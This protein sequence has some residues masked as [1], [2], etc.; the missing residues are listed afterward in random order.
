MLR[1]GQGSVPGSWLGFRAG[2]GTFVSD[3]G[4]L[5]PMA[6]T[7]LRRRGGQAHPGPRAL[8]CAGDIMM[9]QVS[10][11]LR[12]D[13]AARSIQAVRL[14]LRSRTGSGWQRAGGSW[15]R[16]CPIGEVRLRPRRPRPSHRGATTPPQPW[17]DACHLSGTGGN[18][19]GITGKQ[20][21]ARNPSR[22]P[23]QDPHQRHDPRLSPH[24]KPRDGPSDDHALDLRRAL[25]NREAR[26]GAGSFRR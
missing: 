17:P 8:A 5:W 15:P 16:L 3:E 4:G 20:P 14:A 6:G 22:R 19:P 2:L 10:S 21:T 7:G 9:D 18:Q 24:V 13:A 11:R 1:R 12:G 23:F 25:E 26:G